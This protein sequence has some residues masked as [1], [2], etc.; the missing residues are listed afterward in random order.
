[1][2]S[3]RKRISKSVR[4]TI[5]SARNILS[6]LRGFLEDLTVIL[7]TIWELLH[8]ARVLFVLVR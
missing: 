6:E 7:V 3:R 2:S 5:G 4:E 1:M 8:V